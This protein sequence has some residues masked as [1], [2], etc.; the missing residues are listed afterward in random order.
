MD[1]TAARVLDYSAIW[2]HP[3]GSS[4]M[5]EHEILRI[6]AQEEIGRE[7]EQPPPT[8]LVLHLRVIKPDGR[9]SSPSR[10]QGSRR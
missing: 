4:D 7:S 2:V 10:S 8:G 9:S 5:L 6:Q 1:G 3:D